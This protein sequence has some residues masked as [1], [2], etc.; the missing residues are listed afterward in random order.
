MELI[1]CQRIHLLTADTTVQKTQLLAKYHVR[2]LLTL[3]PYLIMDYIILV[4]NEGIVGSVFYIKISLVII[5]NS[6]Q[7][8]YYID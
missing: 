5:M 7:I 2:S 1:V 3:L 4:L 8:M 6:V